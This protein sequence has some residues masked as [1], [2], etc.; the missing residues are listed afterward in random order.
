M[1]YWI[2]FVWV[3]LALGT[4]RT[5]GCGDDEGKPCEERAGLRRTG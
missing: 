2:G 4:L 1:R 3:L 5:V